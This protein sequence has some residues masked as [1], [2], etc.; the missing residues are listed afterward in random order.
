MTTE[1]GV[2]GGNGE[3]IIERGNGGEGPRSGMQTLKIGIVR[4]FRF[5]TP[6]VSQGQRA[7][8]AGSNVGFF[9]FGCGWKFSHNTTLKRVLYYSTGTVG[10]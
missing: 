10:I 4:H 8:H 3:V 7:G 1:P 9:R 6:T 5:P 2:M